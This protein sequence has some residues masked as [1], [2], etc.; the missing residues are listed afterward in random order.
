MGVYD[1]SITGLV[2]VFAKVIWKKKGLTQVK[3]F[4]ILY[5]YCLVSAGKLGKQS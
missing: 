5:V 4:L 1:L 2:A 3:P